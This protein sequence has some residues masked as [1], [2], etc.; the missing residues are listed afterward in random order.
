M[1]NDVIYRKA[2][3]SKETLLKRARWLIK[4]GLW[5]QVLIEC[6][7]Q[8]GFEFKNTDQN[9]WVVYQYVNRF[10]AHHSGST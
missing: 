4:F 7:G 5:E 9:T 10:V 8:E 3:S 2:E 6:C 1:S